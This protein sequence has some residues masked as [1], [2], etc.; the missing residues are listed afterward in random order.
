MSI[1]E[2]AGT[3]LAVGNIIG[4]VLELDPGMLCGD[5][6]EGL[7]DITGGITADGNGVLALQGEEGPLSLLGNGGEKDQD[8]VFVAVVGIGGVDPQGVAGGQRN[9]LDRAGAG[10]L[11]SV[12]EGTV[13]IIGIVHIIPYPVVQAEPTVLP[14]GDAGME[15]NVGICGIIAADGEG[16]LSAEGQDLKPVAVKNDHMRFCCGSGGMGIE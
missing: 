5:I 15:R 12:M 4:A 3:A 10:D 13:G 9:A 14:A 16:I 2:G 1:Q 8:T 7:H 6:G 11:L